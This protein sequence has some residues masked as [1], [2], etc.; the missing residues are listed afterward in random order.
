MPQLPAG[1]LYGVPA[2]MAGQIVLGMS[3]Q[4]PAD[5]GWAGLAAGLLGTAG[6]M[7]MVFGARQIRSGWQLSALF[8]SGGFLDLI[9]AH[10]LDSM[11]VL[12]WL[13]LMTGVA[14]LTVGW[15][16]AARD[17]WRLARTR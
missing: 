4:V 8:G 17:V 1:V 10:F 14:L 9:G 7:L 5:G 12:A 11:P 3:E 2:L 15:V 16:I 6:V 13:A